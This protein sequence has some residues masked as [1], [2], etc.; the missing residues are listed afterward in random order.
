MPSAT[1]NPR[2]LGAGAGFQP[3]FSAAALRTRIARLVFQ[4]LQPEFDRV[5]LGLGGHDVDLGLAGEAVGVVAGGAPGAGGEGVRG[6]A[7][8]AAAEL[9]VR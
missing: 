5:H 3:N 8:E 2:P 4:V 7:A 6:R 1:P 9:I